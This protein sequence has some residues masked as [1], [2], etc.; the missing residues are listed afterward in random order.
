MRRLY[1][2][3]WQRKIERFGQASGVN[4]RCRRQRPDPKSGHRDQ[5]VEADTPCIALVD[6]SY[7]F[8]SMHM[9]FFE[10]WH[11]SLRLKQ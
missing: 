3:A 1:T 10:L 8:F 11:W 6:S 7:I 4:T 5:P 9:F 2:S